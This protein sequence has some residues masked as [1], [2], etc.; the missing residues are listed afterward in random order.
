M[1]QLCGYDEASWCRTLVPLADHQAGDG[2]GRRQ[3]VA[4]EGL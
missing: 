1:T 4:A 2:L 3:R